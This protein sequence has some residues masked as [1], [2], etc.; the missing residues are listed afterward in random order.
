MK[1]FYSKSVNET[2]K[3]LNTTSN[4]LTSEEAKKRLAENGEN[5]LEHKKKTNYFLK[6]LAQFKDIMV[7]ILIVAAI[8]SLVFAI[9]EK[10]STELI[11]SIIIFVIVL[12]NATLGFSQEI[13]AENALD[14]LR[15]MSQP[16]STVIRD[17]EEM[18]VKTSELV[19]G[20]IVLL[21]AGDVVPADLLLIE[22][23]SL[24]CEEASLTGES[25]PV[26][27][28]AGLVLPEKTN[29]GDRKNM[30]FSSTTVVYGRGE[31]VVVA[32]GSN[33]EM[34]KI[35]SMLSE[36][37]KEVTPLQKSLAK[38]G[39]IITFIVLG[40]ALV[41]F[42]VDLLF[43]GQGW[44]DSFLTAVAIAVAAIPESLPAV[45]TIILSIGVTKLAKKNT[46]IKKLHAVETL[47]CCQVIC[48]DKTGT[49]TQNKMTVREVYFNNET[50][51]QADFTVKGEA[52]A[53][54]KCMALCNDAKHQKDAYLGDP[55]EV[56]LVQYAERFKMNKK[57]LESKFKRIGEI[58]FDSVRKLMSTVNKEEDNF[59]QYTKG[60]VDELLRLC[61]H[62]SDNGKVRKI[63][64]KDIDSI[65]Q[66]NKEMGAKALRVLA[67]AT[68]EVPASAVVNDEI[69]SKLIKE[70]GLTF[71]GLSGM[72]DPPRDEVFDAL[73]K[74]REAGMKAIMITGD[75]KDT[76]YA[77]AKE[78][79]M[80]KSEKEVVN[81]SHL[82]KFTDEELVKEIRKFRVFTRVSP[83]H[84]VRIVKALQANGK[85]VA[86]TGDGVN[87]APSIK[88][89]N[90]G[91][92][93]GNVGTEV[94]KD[95]ADMILTDDNF[96]TIVLAVEEGRKIFGNIQKTIQFLLG[97][98]IAEVLSIFAI[99]LLFPQY[100]LFTA[101]QILFTNLVT[102]TFPSIALGCNEAENDLMKQPPRD[103]KQ[104]IIGG[105]VGFNIIYQGFTQAF[106]VLAVYMIGLFGFGS[107]EAATTMAFLTINIVQLFH[108][109]S[110]RTLHSI[111]ASNPFKNKLLN[112][113]F[114]GE[115]AIILLVALCPPVAG[116]LSLTQLSLVQWLIIFGCS[117]LIIP[118]VELVKLG[119][120][121]KDQRKALEEKSE[122]VDEF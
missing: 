116:L 114:V 85:V 103:P 21:E 96:A 48:S 68:K 88:S 55:T 69:D 49:I 117:L 58:P 31:G 72:I 10:S 77:I 43:A 81:G 66:V 82:D 121:K 13:K 6:F 44:M 30:C 5:S 51:T 76:A 71:I 35:A 108:M 93:M 1:S 101:V 91:I 47:G 22:S 24:K 42:L 90:I 112:I 59:V 61:T 19:V 17:G 52:T 34:G 25:L 9:I 80:V 87:D 4:G 15:K 106:I 120:K 41:I 111:F 73:I 33:A 84:K 102:D 104:Y 18:K 75:H 53:L 97:T 26:E 14:A 62:I 50:H 57:S 16:Y 98:N 109:Y 89:A 60:A 118:I 65:K 32:T 113:A 115:L 20:D 28:E 38:L 2:L 39:E 8:I 74:C 70:E 107:P 67:Y 46:I 64:V 95:V 122:S 110:V 11:D 12:I 94:T 63:T 100:T 23:A 99:T 40:I 29:L 37:K 7:L 79:G 86:M 105:R 119:Q 45:V 78:L 83:E 3:E 54:L 36:E 27:K 92:G 56:A